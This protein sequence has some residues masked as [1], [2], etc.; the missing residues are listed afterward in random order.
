MQCFE[1]N[2]VDYRQEGDRLQ[3]RPQSPV[4]SAL[5]AEL[6][7]T[8]SERLRAGTRHIT[9]DLGEADY[10]DSDG[11][12]WLERLRSSIAG[13]EGTLELSVR[14]GSRVE[15]AVRLLQLD[16]QMRV[17]HSGLENSEL[18]EPCLQR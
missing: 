18:P 14:K 15:R 7:S 13:S 9:L 10:V 4:D 5:V 17:S 3:V 16:S 12:R 11:F 8:L 2:G 6:D 1:K